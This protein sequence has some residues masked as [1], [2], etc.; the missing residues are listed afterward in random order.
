[1][2]RIPVM[3]SEQIK[4]SPQSAIY[5]LLAWEAY[6]TAVETFMVQPLSDL[7]IKV[8]KDTWR[9]A[10]MTHARRHRHKHTYWS[11]SWAH[12]WSCRRGGKHALG[13]DP[14]TMVQDRAKFTNGGLTLPI[15]C[16]VTSDTSL[17]Q[18][19][20]KNMSKKGSNSEQLI[21]PSH[22]WEVFLE[23]WRE[24]R[25]RVTCPCKPLVV[26]NMWRASSNN[27]AKSIWCSVAF[28]ESVSLLSLFY[29]LPI[30]KQNRCLPGLCPWILQ[31]CR[32]WQM[33]RYH[34]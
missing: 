27:S 7:M 17:Q 23:E 10:G 24:G 3:N 14:C 22:F 18:R 9:C 26:F 31:I 1:M 28:Q 30:N 11:P 32:K 21:R 15:F 12:I 2:C 25:G 16:K 34:S 29:F 4:P 19:G 33:L 6:A 13:G 5:I 8:D 20:C